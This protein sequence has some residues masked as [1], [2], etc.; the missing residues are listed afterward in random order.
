M[1]MREM[2]M[3]HAA[4]VL[5]CYGASHNLSGFGYKP[6]HPISWAPQLWSSYGHEPTNL[7]YGFLQGSY[8]PTSKH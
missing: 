5:I 4:V 6:G 8:V 2:V 7:E 1:K 3:G